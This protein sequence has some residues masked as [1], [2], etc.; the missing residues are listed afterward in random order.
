MAKSLWP[1]LAGRHLAYTPHLH[2]TLKTGLSE[3]L[4]NSRAAQG[5]RRVAGKVT[6]HAAAVARKVVKMVAGM[7]WQDTQVR[8]VWCP[9]AADPK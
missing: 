9:V 6:K 5:G 2:T 7:H 8:G 3:C 4:G 1:E